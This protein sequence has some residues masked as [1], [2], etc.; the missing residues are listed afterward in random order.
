MITVKVTYADGNTVTTGIN[1]SFEEAK[2]YYFSNVFNIGRGEN[3]NMQRAVK[4]E[5]IKSE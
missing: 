3:D 5:E 1:L 4:V 2:R